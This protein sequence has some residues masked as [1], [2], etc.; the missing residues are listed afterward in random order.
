MGHVVLPLGTEL[1]LNGRVHQNALTA[2]HGN[3]HLRIVAHTIGKGSAAAKYR[4]ADTKLIVGQYAGVGRVVKTQIG[5]IN[6]LATGQVVC[7]GN[8]IASAAKLIAQGA[9]AR[10]HHFAGRRNTI[11]PII[12]IAATAARNGQR[13]LPVALVAA[14]GGNAGLR[15]VGYLQTG[16]I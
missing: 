5:S 4:R 9:V 16:I 3:A 10:Q 6:R 1:L 7:N 14:T 15:S 13:N 12:G 8:G 11:A 2:E